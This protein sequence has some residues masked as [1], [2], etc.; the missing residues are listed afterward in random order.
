[1]RAGGVSKGMEICFDETNMIVPEPGGRR[2][3][4]GNFFESWQVNS[5]AGA[6]LVEERF[7]TIFEKSNANGGEDVTI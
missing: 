7:S 6:S 5:S 1:M 3:T 4:R 2:E